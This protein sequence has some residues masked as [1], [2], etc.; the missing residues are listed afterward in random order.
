MVISLVLSTSD[1][2]IDS[3][4]RNNI[5]ALS[6][7]SASRLFLATRHQPSP[8]PPPKTATT[9]AHPPCLEKATP[10]RLLGVFLLLVRCPTCLHSRF[11]SGL[12]SLVLEQRG[13]LR[14]GLG[15][16]VLRAALDAVIAGPAHYPL[17]AGNE[18]SHRAVPP[19]Q[20]FQ[21]LVRVRGADVVG[22]GKGRPGL[23]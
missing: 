21:D 3:A 13:R 10:G 12:S 9:T 8:F 1:K 6:R 7:G 11:C 5:D 17:V 15:L 2:P 20:A 4:E 23:H 19:L 14:V 18:S 22:A 16:A